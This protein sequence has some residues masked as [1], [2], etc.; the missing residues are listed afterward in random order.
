M[1][2]TADEL[3]EALNNCNMADI[4]ANNQRKFAEMRQIMCVSNSNKILNISL[5]LCISIKYMVHYHVYGR[6]TTLA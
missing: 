5:G 1:Y 2:K 6:C 4:S 3:A